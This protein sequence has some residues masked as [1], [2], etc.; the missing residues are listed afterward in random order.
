MFKLLIAT[1][2]SNV[3]NNIK[4][5]ALSAGFDVTETNDG[6]NVIQ[7]CET[8]KF[9]IIIMDTILTKLDGFSVCKEIRKTQNIPIIFISSSGSER[10]K[11][12]GFEVGAD[13]FMVKPYSIKVLMARINAIFLRQTGR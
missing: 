13:D 10:D 3:S 5:Y 9:D 2:E 7:M 12:H 4:E 8:S 11:I 6:M 1:N